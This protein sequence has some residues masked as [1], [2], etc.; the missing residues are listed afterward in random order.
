MAWGVGATTHVRPE[1]EQ[2]ERKRNGAGIIG[3]EQAG[4]SRAQQVHGLL[5]QIERRASQLGNFPLHPGP[6]WVGQMVPLW[7]LAGILKSILPIQ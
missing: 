7:T 1:V 2:A 6:K 5:D 4:G 3:Q